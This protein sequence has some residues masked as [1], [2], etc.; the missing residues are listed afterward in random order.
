MKKKKKHIILPFLLF[1]TVT[2]LF[3]I[4]NT[5]CYSKHLTKT[6]LYRQTAGLVSESWHVGGPVGE[7]KQFNT[8]TSAERE[9]S[10]GGQVEEEQVSL[11]RLI[12]RGRSRKLKAGEATFKIKRT[13]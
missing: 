1:S 6:F 4:P 11:M 8:L 10:A 7:R 13:L 5:S 12:D 2:Q 9:T 3:M